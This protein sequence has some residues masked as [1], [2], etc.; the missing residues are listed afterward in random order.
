MK[1]EGSIVKSH[2]M[3]ID[4]NVNSLDATLI[5]NQSMSEEWEYTYKKYT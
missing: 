4:I 1:C 3:K 5:I 2:S